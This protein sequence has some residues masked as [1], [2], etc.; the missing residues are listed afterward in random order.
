MVGPRTLDRVAVGS[1]N[2]GKIEAVRRALSDGVIAARLRASA[3]EGYA[4]ASGVPDHPV[5]FHETLVGA[6]NRA[7]GAYA[8]ALDPARTMTVWGVGLESGFV[9]LS[10]EFSSV[11]NFDV[12]CVFDGQRDWFGVSCGVEYPRRL[13]E[14]I[15][16]H[17]QDFSTARQFI[18]A[19]ADLE[20][21]GGVLGV[22]TAGV[23]DRIGTAEQAVKLAL[24]RA[25]DPAGKY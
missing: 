24:V 25:L 15:F 1:R 22:L 17:E 7:R 2:A 12:S 16:V 5:G 6:R 13:C 14:N 19:S 18:D 11:Y 4:V 8:A 23:V 21:K 10:P 3:V 9:S 20:Q